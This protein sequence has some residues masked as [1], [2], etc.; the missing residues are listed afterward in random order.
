MDMMPDGDRYARMPFR[1]TGRRGLML[2]PCRSGSGRTLAGTGRSRRS[3][4]SS[5]APSTSVSPTSTWPTTTGCLWLRRGELRPD[6]EGRPGGAPRLAGHLHQGRLRHV[7][8][9]LRDLGL[10]KV[11][12]RQPG[13]EPAADGARVRR[14]LLLAPVRPG[15]AARGDDGRA[16]IGFTADAP[17]ANLVAPIPNSQLPPR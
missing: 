4:P 11:P 9:A 8:R 17:A 1:R 7:A 12:A 2:P 13:P 10:A 16:V 6:H 5:G 14:H 3:G 15:N